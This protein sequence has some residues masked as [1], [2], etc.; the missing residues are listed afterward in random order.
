MQ[1]RPMP[2]VGAELELDIVDFTTDGRA[3]ARQGGLV[4]FLD[5][6]LIGERARVRVCGHKK[7]SVLA[8]VVQCLS[9]SPHA[10]SPFCVRFGECG[11]CALQN[12]DYSAQLVWKRDRLEAALRR[13]GGVPA[14]VPAVLPSPRLAGYRNKME[15]AFGQGDTGV[16]LGLR[17]RYSHV[18][19]DL[20]GCALQSEI[21]G[22]IL[23]A[24]KFWARRHGLDAW[25]GSEGALRFF[26]LR[27]PEFQPEGK[28]QRLAELIC[29]SRVPE[30]EAVNGLW[31]DLRQLG[32]ASFVLSRCAANFSVAKGEKIL[33]RMGQPK[34]WEKIGALT[35]SFPPESFVQTN[36]GAA[37]LLYAEVEEMAALEGK[38]EVWDIYSGVGA[39]ALYLAGK[40]KLVRGVELDAVAVRAAKENAF[41]F[42]FTHCDFAAG[43]AGKVFVA[44]P[45]RPD[46]LV[47]D[48]PRG[49]MHPALIQGIKFKA[50]ARIVHVSCDPATLARDLAL[51]APEYGLER[52]LAV[53]M[54]PHTPHVESVV[55]LI[56]T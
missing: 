53:D 23:G 41:H 2:A 49:G 17:K 6:G 8:E 4:F 11:G 18:V 43:D 45:G 55:L 25:N 7:S 21:S 35:F 5:S 42:G 40:A 51:L 30:A 19:C 1:M 29:G 13:L 26:I 16:L 44:L 12:F 34:L 46:V 22:A 15:Y 14:R 20:E 47:L 28:P 52:C 36:T 39:L 37:A 32:V 31:Q 3:V 9:P 38:E 50:P 24:V 56:K 54:F 27:E 48:P 33:R 10:V